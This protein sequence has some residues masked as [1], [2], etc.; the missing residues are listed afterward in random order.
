[1]QFKLYQCLF[2]LN[3][4][5]CDAVDSISKF[6]TR[7]LPISICRILRKQLSRLTQAY[8]KYEDHR[9]P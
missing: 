7:L 9:Q 3:T 8:Y 2:Y 5:T 6:S 1:M 4:T